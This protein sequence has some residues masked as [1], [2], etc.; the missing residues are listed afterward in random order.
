MEK[1]NQVIS[2]L[3]NAHYIADESLATMLSLA[4][5]MGRPLLV[6]GP[7]G[8]GK[9]TLAYAL[10]KALGRS[11]I[12]LQCFEGMDATHA[13]YDWNY[14][15]QLAK[16]S[17]KDDADVFSEPYLLARPL[18][19]A[20]QAK[21]GAVLLIDEVD[22]A[23]EAFEALLLEFLAEYQ[24][25]VPE[26]GTVTAQQRPAVV[27][28]SNSTRALSDAL[29]R[30]CLYIHMGWPPASQ[31]ETVVALHVPELS[32]G[33]VTRIVATVRMLREFELMKRPGVAESIDWA[34]AFALTD[35]A[36]WNESFIRAT[37]GCVIKD[38]Y[39][40]QAVLERLDELL[41]TPT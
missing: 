11:L 25:T 34:K 31:E 13:L 3:A 19:Q 2:L 28:T 29:R 15:K 39:D 33:M 4:Q 16:L 17:Q 20:L 36:S 1:V 18:M 41:D 32:A 12:R 6:D 27:L 14:H 26:W 5:A 22:R 8:V 21:E 30:R 10:S 23:D 40:M 7:A 35:G 37:L 9:T 24:I 38:A